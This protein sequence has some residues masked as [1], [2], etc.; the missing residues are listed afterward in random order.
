MNFQIGD[1]VRVSFGSLYVTRRARIKAIWENLGS[2]SFETLND[3]NQVTGEAIRPIG[4]ITPL[5]P[6]ELLAMEAP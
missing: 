3:D 6:L 4:D 2:I 1:I 5:S